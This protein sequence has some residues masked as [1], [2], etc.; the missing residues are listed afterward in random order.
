MDSDGVGVG[1]RPFID[2]AAD[3]SKLPNNLAAFDHVLVDVARHASRSS[4]DLRAAFRISEGK[5]APLS[6]DAD[7]NPCKK[8]GTS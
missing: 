8:G 4:V 3:Y 5:A 1:N 2:P 6:A 7:Q